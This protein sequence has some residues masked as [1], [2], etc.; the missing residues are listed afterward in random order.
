LKRKDQQSS[1]QPDPI[2]TRYAEYIKTLQNFVGV[3]EA[4]PPNPNQNGN[5]SVIEQS[6]RKRLAD[7][8]RRREITTSLQ[9][10]FGNAFLGQL[11]TKERLK[12]T[13]FIITMCLLVVALFFVGYILNKITKQPLN[14]NTE[15][16]AAFITAVV[17]GVTALLVL[18]RII[19]DYLFNKEEHVAITALLSEIINKDSPQLDELLPKE[20]KK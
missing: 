10:D 14:E 19:A 8:S 1:T 11:K 3:Q 6:V 12:I 20:N 4:E 13:F 9:K 7:D 17:G 5:E 16:I 18:P 2:K 15:A